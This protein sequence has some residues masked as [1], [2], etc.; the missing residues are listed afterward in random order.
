[1][2]RQRVDLLLRG[3][4]VASGHVCGSLGTHGLYL[5]KRED[6]ILEDMGSEK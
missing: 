1:M 6:R 2:F 3:H 5:D 4:L